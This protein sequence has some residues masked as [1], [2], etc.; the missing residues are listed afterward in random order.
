MHKFVL[1]E[2]T[3]VL[4]LNIFEISSTPKNIVTNSWLWHYT[5]SPY[6]TAKNQQI[7]DKFPDKDNSKSISLRA[8]VFQLVFKMQI[9]SLNGFAN[10]LFLC[11]LM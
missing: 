1:C 8:S 6:D 10:I 11:D 5:I 7:L 3:C 4:W 2:G 9:I